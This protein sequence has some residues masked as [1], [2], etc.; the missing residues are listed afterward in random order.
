[1]NELYHTLKVKP[2]ASREEIHRSFRRLAKETHPDLNGNDSKKVAQ[3]DQIKKAYDILSDPEKR[4]KYDADQ[5]KPRTA[6]T[7]S[8]YTGGMNEEVRNRVLALL[9]RQIRVKKH[10]TYHFFA[11][12]VILILGIGVIG[13]RRTYE[14]QQILS[15]LHLQTPLALLLGLGGLAS[16][17]L[18][19]IV[20]DSI[21]ILRIHFKLKRVLKGKG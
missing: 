17:I 3:F 5:N 7:S 15:L 4:A 14:M 10:R 8:G 2:N 9:D 18:I 16:L 1:M 11:G 19:L 13:L 21:T 6:P 20:I 12:C